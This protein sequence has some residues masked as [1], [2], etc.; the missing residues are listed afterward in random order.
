MQFCR[1][2]LSRCLRNKLHLHRYQALTC[3][4]R[5]EALKG[6]QDVK[7]DFTGTYLAVKRFGAPFGIGYS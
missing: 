6:V 3:Q 1:L 5:E 2:T 7:N 4:T